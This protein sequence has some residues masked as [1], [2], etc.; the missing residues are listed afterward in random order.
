[1]YLVIC[2][3]SHITDIVYQVFMPLIWLQLKRRRLVTWSTTHIDCISRQLNYCMQLFWVI[4]RSLM[5]LTRTW[6][7]WG[8]TGKSRTTC[9]IWASV[10]VLCDSHPSSSLFLYLL[11]IKY[12]INEYILTFKN[13]SYGITVKCFLHL[14]QHVLAKC[15]FRVHPNCVYLASGHWWH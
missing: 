7:K 4:V 6:A 1:M 3:F 15:D 8:S 5:S 13:F 12:V 2:I 10:E 9:K 11:T 14:Y